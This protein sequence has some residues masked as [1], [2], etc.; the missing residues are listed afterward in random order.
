MKSFSCPG[1][2]YSTSKFSKFTNHVKSQCGSGD[3]SY[4]CN[5]CGGGN[6]GDVPL[7]Y[8]VFY[9]LPVLFIFT[10]LV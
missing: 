6:E 5:Q 2:K 8:N 7:K 3:Q 10:Y 1:C 4:D 9:L